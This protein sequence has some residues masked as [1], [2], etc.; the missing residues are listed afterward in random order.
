MAQTYPTQ[1]RSDELPSLSKFLSVEQYLNT[2]YRPDVDYVDGEIEERNLGDWDHGNLQLFIGAL[3]LARQKEWGV[4]V[5][6]ESRVRVSPTRVRIPDVCV[7]AA[8]MERER[9]VVHRPPLLCVEVLSPRDSLKTMRKRVQDF[10]D[11]GVEHV[12]IFDPATRTAHACT[13]TTIAEH[14]AGTLRVPDT[15]IALSVEEIFSTLDA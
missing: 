8:D 5:A 3:F 15:K 10:F 9:K 6:V 2:T 7:V 1:T 14:K 12:W 13:P 4:R 11:M